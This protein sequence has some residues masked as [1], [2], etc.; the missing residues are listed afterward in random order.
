[1]STRPLIG[2]TSS[3]NDEETRISVNRNFHDVLLAA[4][5][6]PVLLP[7]TGEPDALEAMIELCDGFVF[8]GGDDV[9]PRRY[10]EQPRPVCGSITPDRDDC[11]LPL[12]SMLHQRH[13]KPVL[14]ICRGIQAM[15][16]SL[17]GMLYQDLANDFGKPVLAHRQKMQGKYSSHSIALSE[18][19]LL[20]RIIQTE[21]IDVNSFH[22]QAVAKVAPG[23]IA[24]AFAPDGIIESIESTTHP[25]FLGVQWHPE[26]MWRKDEKALKLFQALVK[27]CHDPHV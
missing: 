14:A 1:M 8:S 17:G 19:T 10:G 22:H 6:M 9:D 15:N 5:A 16:V 27:A 26:I 25:F 7:I 24:T 11:E 4:G 23:M 18:N 3:L 12:V 2:I 13:D 20:H 21:T